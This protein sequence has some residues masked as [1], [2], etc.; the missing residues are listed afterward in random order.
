MGLKMQNEFI[1]D[2]VH[3]VENCL[4]EKRVFNNFNNKKSLHKLL[5]LATRTY[6]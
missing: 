6:I 3:V 1:R 2:A 4:A 5:Q